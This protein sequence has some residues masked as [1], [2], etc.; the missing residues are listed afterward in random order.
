VVVVKH[1]GEAQAQA[2]LEGGAPAE[3]LNEK[4]LETGD[5]RADMAEAMDDLQK[6]MTRVNEIHE[7]NNAAPKPP[8]KAKVAFGDALMGEA[9]ASAAE[10]DTEGEQTQGAE[11]EGDSNMGDWD[12]D[13]HAPNIRPGASC[14]QALRTKTP[15]AIGSARM[16]KPESW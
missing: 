10:G 13:E 5:L 7:E 4:E 2:V 11:E 12:E 16:W 1:L 14:R 15:E 6:G 9:G 8:D 3:E